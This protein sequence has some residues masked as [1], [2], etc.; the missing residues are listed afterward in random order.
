MLESA[1][2]LEPGPVPDVG[3]ASV[4]MTT[5]ITLQDAAVLGPVEEGSPVLQLVHPVRRFL[6]VQLCHPPVVHELPAP[7]R[8]AEV[9]SPVVLRVDIPQSGGD[10]ALGHHRMRLS[11]QRFAYQSSARPL[12]RG[13][14][15]GP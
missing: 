14:H 5:K 1:D 7:H 3:Q 10:P 13:L 4:A 8:V 11:Q 9:D 2:Q 12:S 15:R 6:G